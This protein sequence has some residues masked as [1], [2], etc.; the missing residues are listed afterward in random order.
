LDDID[1]TWQVGFAG[2]GGWCV[3]QRDVQVGPVVAPSDDRLGAMLRSGD[4]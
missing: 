3:N 4:V 2:G 1:P